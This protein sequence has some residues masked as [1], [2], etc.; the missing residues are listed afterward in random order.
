MDDQNEKGLMVRIGTLIDA[1]ISAQRG[2]NNAG[3]TLDKKTVTSNR[4]TPPTVTG[5]TKNI[6]DGISVSLDPSND[7]S[8]LSNYEVQVDSDPAFSDPT[9]KSAFSTDM[10][11]KGLTAETDYHVRARALS[12]DGVVTDWFG[13]DTVATGQSPGVNTSDIDGTLNNEQRASKTFR[14]DNDAEDVFIVSNFGNPTLTYAAEPFYLSSFMGESLQETISLDGKEQSSSPVSYNPDGIFTVR[15]WPLAFFSLIEP[16]D[17]PSTHHFYVET[18][19]NVLTI[20]PV[21][22]VKF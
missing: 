15:F 21:V 4:S 14:F 2:T 9:T 17:S 3:A 22:W 10:T 6:F 20:N 13:L 19:D 12:K 11:F 1:I 7:P 8:N 5:T 16:G 18:Q